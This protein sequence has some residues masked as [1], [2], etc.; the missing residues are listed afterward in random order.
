MSVIDHPT[1]HLSTH[2]SAPSSSL[3]VRAWWDPELA[4]KGF[5]PR[6]AYVERYWLGVI[7]PS[8][9]LL[10]R[11]FAR[12]LEEHPGGFRADLADTARALGLGAGTGKQSPI[13]RTID[14]AC[15]F[16]TMRRAGPDELEVRTHLPRLSRR[17]LE[18]LPEVVR[19]SHDS[20]LAHPANGSHG[21]S[22]EPPVPPVPPSAA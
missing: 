3:V 13:V 17:Q 5:D 22:P 11:R 2:E 9:L 7:G 18:R 21:P 19:R 16:G 1:R 12:G 20:W 10:I 14:R 15:L 8:A 4:T 6:G